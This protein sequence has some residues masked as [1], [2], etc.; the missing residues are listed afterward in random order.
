MKLRDLEPGKLAVV[1]HGWKDMTAG[2]IVSIV[3]RDH[4]Y[5]AI[6]AGN[7]SGWSM[8]VFGHAEVRQLGKDDQVVIDDQGALQ[9]RNSEAKKAEGVHPSSLKVG[10]L[11][12]A[13]NHDGFSGFVSGCLVMR[14]AID[15]EKRKFVSPD[16]G[17]FA[18]SFLSTFLVKP[19]PVGSKIVPQADGSI[20]VEEP[21][22]TAPTTVRVSD[23]KR[24]DYFTDDDDDLGIKTDLGVTWLASERLEDVGFHQCDNTVRAKTLTRK[25]A[26]EAGKIIAGG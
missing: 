7:G 14:L 23:L 18:N 21:G 13:I 12:R 8:T 26:A 15:G 6:V 9:L 10:Q 16:L 20:I 2:R 24:G 3:D 17:Q 19:Y 25:T 5:A 22:V 11:G 1:V 4:E